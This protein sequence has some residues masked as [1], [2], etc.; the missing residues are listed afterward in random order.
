MQHTQ[1]LIID[2]IKSIDE[3]ISRRKIYNITGIALIPK[4]SNGGFNAPVL[5]YWFI[6]ENLR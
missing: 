5:N 3:Y 6:E 1:Y 4:R 2:K